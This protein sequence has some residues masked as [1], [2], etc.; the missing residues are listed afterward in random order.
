[1]APSWMYPAISAI[2]AVPTS[3]EATHLARMNAN[4]KAIKP[5]TGTINVKSTIFSS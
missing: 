3:C 2:S 4:T 5:A 1:M